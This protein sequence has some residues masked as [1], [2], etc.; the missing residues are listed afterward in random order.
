MSSRRRVG[1]AAPPRVDE[2]VGLQVNRIV[3]EERAAI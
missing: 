2:V 1:L 3:N